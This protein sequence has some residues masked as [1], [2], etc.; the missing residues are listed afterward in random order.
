[1]S[2]ITV[3]IPVHEFNED[4]EL[5]LDKAVESV[6]KQD[7]VDAPKICIVASP[8]IVVEIHKNKRF[9]NCSFI[10]NHKTTDFQTQINYALNV[11]DTEYFSVLEFDDEYNTTYFTNVAKYIK[12]MPEVDIFMPMIID[13]DSEGKGLSTT[14][15][16]V[17][18]QQ[19]VGE[20]GKLGV[21]NMDT[22][23]S[24]MEFNLSGAIIKTETFKEIGGY[25]ANIELTFGY[26]LLLRALNNANNVFV[27]P[28]IGYKH[29]ATR[30]GSM[31]DVYEKTLLKPE[32]KFWYEVALKE[33]MF[34]NDREID[35]TKLKK[36]I[37]E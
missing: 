17:W 8:E 24:V 34:N 19:F 36:I 11:V 33:Y 14:N 1:M 35:T 7:V 31:F 27:I 13:V 2:N 25:K 4:I 16:A 12:S 10:L 30:V 5:M 21:L 15:Q 32:R 18:S 28:K 6:E 37:V 22:L 29:L 23:K 3:I 20:N 9:K 26:E